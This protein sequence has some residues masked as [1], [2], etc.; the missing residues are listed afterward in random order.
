MG[1]ISGS[2]ISRGE[3]HGNLLQYSCLDNARDRGAWWVAV[4][5]VTKSRTQL[6]A[7][8]LYWG[9][10]PHINGPVQFRLALFKHKVYV[11]VIWSSVLFCC[12][13]QTA[14]RRSEHHISA[15]AF[16]VLPQAT[17]LQLL[18]LLLTCL[19]SRPPA[20]PITPS[21]A[22]PPVS[23]CLR[24]LWPYQGCTLLHCLFCYWEYCAF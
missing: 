23:P 11:N 20:D 2:G 17:H 12:L 16:S 1:S 19:G 4:H 18:P 24:T 21:W 15:P 14:F 5:G 9:K 10:D 6:S 3:G 22:C 8:H 7:A 13:S